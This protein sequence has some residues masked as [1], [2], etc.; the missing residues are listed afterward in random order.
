VSL[1]MVRSTMSGRSSHGAPARLAATTPV[2]LDEQAA[3]PVPTAAS[4]SPP[5]SSCQVRGRCQSVADGT[6]SWPFPVQAS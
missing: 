5:R 2:A 6:S 1:S 3:P 4:A